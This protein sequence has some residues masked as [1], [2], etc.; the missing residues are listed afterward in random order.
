MTRMQSTVFFRTFTS[1]AQNLAAAKNKALGSIEQQGAAAAL[2]RC[3]ELAE[4]ICVKLKA[5]KPGRL[6]TRALAEFQVALERAAS[7]RFDLPQ[8]N[9]RKSIKQNSN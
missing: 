7:V 4:E 8:P 5:K 9:G 2:E 1:Y 6:D 3:R